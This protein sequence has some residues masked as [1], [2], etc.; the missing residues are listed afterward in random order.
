M[1]NIA[2]IREA[3]A[4]TGKLRASINVGNPVLARRDSTEANPIGVSIDIAR[5]LAEHLGME[6][7][8]VVFT[9]AQQSV[10]AVADGKTDVGFFAIDPARGESIAFTDPYLHIEGWYAVHVDSPIQALEEVDNPGVRVAVSGGSAYDLF[11]SRTLKH[12]EI[13]RAPNP[14]AVVN[15]F[16]EQRLEVMANVKQQLELDMLHF[17]GLR[18]LPERFM[19]IRQAMGLPRN[20]GVEGHAYLAGFVEELKASSFIEQALKRHAIQGAVAKVPTAQ[21]DSCTVSVNT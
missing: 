4:P 21:L 5:A 19:V 16:L 1:S 18:L 7:E 2:K 17:P 8:F 13:L 12:A 6:I 14:Q 3:L 20:R 10:D 9:S 15:Y 11:L